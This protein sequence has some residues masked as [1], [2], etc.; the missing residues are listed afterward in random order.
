MTTSNVI[1]IFN[2]VVIPGGA[3]TGAIQQVSSWVPLTNPVTGLLQAYTDFSVTAN[4]VPSGLVQPIWSLQLLGSNNGGISSFPILAPAPIL[5]ANG[6]VVSNSV[7]SIMSSNSKVPAWTTRGRHY[8]PTVLPCQGVAFAYLQA[9]FNLYNP[10]G[11]GL[12][13]TLNVEVAPNIYAAQG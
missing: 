12:T 8:D 11:A 1:R 3:Y 4:A 7:N 9:I 6:N 13:V 10:Q 2:N 5:D